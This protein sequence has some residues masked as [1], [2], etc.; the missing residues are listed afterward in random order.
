VPL[1]PMLWTGTVYFNTRAGK[2]HAAR[3]KVKVELP[4][5]QGEGTKFEYESAYNEDAVEK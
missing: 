5:Y 4:N 1:V 3:L 2:Y